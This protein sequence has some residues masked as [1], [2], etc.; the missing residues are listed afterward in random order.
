MSYLDPYF[1]LISELK[2][3]LELWRTLGGHDV[4]PHWRKGETLLREG[5]GDDVYRW[6]G[7]DLKKGS[8]VGITW[9]AFDLKGR[10][11][12]KGLPEGIGR[13]PCLETVAVFSNEARNAKLLSRLIG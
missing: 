13:L 3:L 12:E 6:S 1:C 4:G 11:P 8:V 9:L 5:H 10:L 7:I 2:T